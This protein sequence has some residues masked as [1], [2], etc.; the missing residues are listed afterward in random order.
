MKI[1]L[2]ENKRLTEA[3]SPSMPK[4]FKEKLTR[5]K[6]AWERGGEYREHPYLYAK[7]YP[8][9]KLIGDQQYDK[10]IS[11][12]YNLDKFIKP[13]YAVRGDHTN[14]YGILL[15]KHFNLSSATFITPDHLPKNG[16]DPMVLEPNIPIWLV[17]GISGYYQVYMKG[18]NDDEI[19]QNSGKKFAYA[20]VKQL[21]STCEGFCYVDGRALNTFDTDKV[22][23]R[24]EFNLQNR[25]GQPN[26]YYRYFQ[27]NIPNQYHLKNPNHI[28]Q[29]A[30]ALD[31]SGY[32]QIPTVTKYAE[33]LRDL[34]ANNAAA[35]L[36]KCYNTIMQYK[37][38]FTDFL[39]DVDVKDG[40]SVNIVSTRHVLS[41]FNS[42]VDY[43]R[44]M[45]DILNNA[46]DIEDIRRAFDAG[47][48]ASQLDYYIKQL[49]DSTSVWRTVVADWD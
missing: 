37:N 15:A 18:F 9:A 10:Y 13:S 4:W 34:K 38:D 33:K 19:W 42:C 27:G 44:D 24:R 5:D 1:K 16:N 20:S 30:N 3:F 47:G 8:G 2:I 46:T 39:Y 21:N 35:W 25:P 32:A 12:G 17:R 22:V 7:D 23:A 49:N 28:K 11:R 14:L 26:S 45:C 48:V 43:Y 40:N 6:T 29:P 36:E 41:A 31:K